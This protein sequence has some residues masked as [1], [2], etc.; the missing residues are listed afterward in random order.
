VVR[1]CRCLWRNISSCYGEVEA[2][3][4]LGY[5]FAEGSQARVTLLFRLLFCSCLYRCRG[6]CVGEVQARPL[7]GCHISEISQA[8]V[9]FVVCIVTGC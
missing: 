3:Q 5:H 2:G 4:L 7:L 8:H 6:N 1:Y 9:S